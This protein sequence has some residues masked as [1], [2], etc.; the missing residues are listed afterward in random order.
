VVLFDSETSD[1]HSIGICGMDSTFLYSEQTSVI[2]IFCHA[3]C[4]SLKSRTRSYFFG[5]DKEDTTVG[6]GVG[7]TGGPAV[8]T[9]RKD[10]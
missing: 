2:G 5:F 9:M 1:E 10:Y 4:L 7:R 6:R 3:F 8:L